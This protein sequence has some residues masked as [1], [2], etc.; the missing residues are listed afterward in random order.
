MAEQRETEVVE[1]PDGIDF[2]QALYDMNRK[3]VT[4]IFFEDDDEERGN[5]LQAKFQLTKRLSDEDA[6]ELLSLQQRRP[7]PL[8]NFCAQALYHRDEKADGV[9]MLKRGNLARKIQGSADPDAPFPTI[10]L[11]SKQ[12]KMIL[13]QGEHV[14]TTLVYTNIHHIIE[15]ELD[16]EDD[17]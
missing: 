7:I 9:Q 12:K 6:E 10:R 16:E 11:S 13:D 1:L 14:W 17:E 4:E 5:H 3:P 8:G 2:N 15:G